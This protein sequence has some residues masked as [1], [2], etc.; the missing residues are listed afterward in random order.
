MACRGSAVPHPECVVGPVG[1]ASR[2][3]PA[4]GRHPPSVPVDCASLVGARPS[5]LECEQE[6]KS[7]PELGAASGLRRLVPQRHGD[8]RGFFSETWNR[9]TAAEHGVDAE[10]VQ[11][12]QSLSVEVGTLRGL[13]FQ[14]PPFAQAKLVRCGRGRL[15]D[16]A[17]DIRV[18][19]P[20]YGRWYGCE[21]P[22][23][24]GVQLFIPEGFLH[25]F[26][27]LE[28]DT[29]LLYK[30]TN[31]YSAEHDASVHWA[32]PELAID[33]GLGDREP[34]LSEKDAEAPRLA[35]IDNPF[36]YGADA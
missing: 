8:A 24:N 21:L 22:A 35:A 30:C 34:T 19:S 25:G 11:D 5:K 36:R 15:F 28:S 17:V 20:T 13:H 32:D 14:R 4:N 18:G 33:W 16:V 1:G 29:E 26:V 6:M 2:Q 7:S 10:F 31:H 9:R 23:E 3:G 27:T 12:N